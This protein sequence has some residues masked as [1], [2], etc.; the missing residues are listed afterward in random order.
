MPMS[1]GE[2]G[3][4]Y[5]GRP[6]SGAQRSV[7]IAGDTPAHA[8]LSDRQCNEDSCCGIY[9]GRDFLAVSYFGSQ[10]NAGEGMTISCWDLAGRR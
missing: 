3:P 8:V 2:S 7:C 1:H 9:Q 5:F 10:V 6:A 4:V